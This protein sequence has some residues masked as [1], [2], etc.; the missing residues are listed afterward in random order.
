MGVNLHERVT[1]YVS[2]CIGINLLMCQPTTCLSTRMAINQLLGQHTWVST[3][4][5]MCQPP[6]ISSRIAVKVCL[7]LPTWVPTYW[8][9]NL[10]GCQT[11]W[12]SNF[13]CVNLKRWETI[14]AST[15]ITIN[16]LTCQSAHESICLFVNVHM[17]HPAGVSTWVG[18]NPLSWRII[19]Y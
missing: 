16:L 10:H 9:V 2:L 6:Y 14:H 5:L 15:C 17:F 18:I 13:F 3:G 11:A 12:L 7:S 8:F 1:A 19:I 4:M